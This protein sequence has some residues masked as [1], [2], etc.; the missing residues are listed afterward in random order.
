MPNFVLKEQPKYPLV[1]IETDT[2]IPELRISNLLKEKQGITLCVRSKKGNK[3][4]GGY[5]FCVEKINIDSFRLL[6]MESTV[7]TDNINLNK[8]TK[9][10]NHV[11]GLAFDEAM[12]LYCQNEI[13]FREDES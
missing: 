12:L 2:A 11:S 8:L 3:K 13:N 9:L 7:I 4:R 10:V 1:S 5:F 6:T